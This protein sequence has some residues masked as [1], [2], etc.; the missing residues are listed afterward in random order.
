[1]SAPTGLWGRGPFRWV[2]SGETLSL[3]GD[4]SFQIVLAWLVLILSG[5]PA[6]LAGVLVA[7]AIPRGILLLVGGAV[8]DRWSPRTV[9]LVCH[10][11]RGAAMATL[12][13]SAATGRLQ[14]WQFLAVAV[15][16]GVADAFFWPASA[17]ILP[18][19]VSTAQLPRANAITAVGEQVGGLVGPVLGGLLLAVTTPTAALAFNTLTFAVAAATIARAPACPRAAHGGTRP[20]PVRAMVRDLRDGVG[21]AVADSRIRIVLLLVSAATLSYSGLFA[22]G[23]PALART[24]PNG[25]VVLGLLVS[26]WGLGQ[27]TGAL[28]ASITGLPRRWGLL[29][30]IMTFCEGAAFAVLGIAP[31]YLIAIPLLAVL[32]VGVA[33]TT[34]VAL[35]AFVQGQTPA[36]LLGR[37]NSVINLPRVALEPASIAGMGLLVQVDLRLTF[38]V[39]ALPMLLVGIALGLSPTARRLQTPHVERPREG[40][41]GGGRLPD[42]S[43]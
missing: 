5:S 40:R 1:M 6:T 28:L 8:T 13:A 25:S 7:A 14:T 42:A 17:S 18:S 2:V 37:V 30:I 16:L 26:A 27:L 22:V 21:Q 29:I 23:L 3:I 32:G 36:H 9:M 43:P 24:S 38:V 10:L 20:Q 4:S 31:T 39:A 11:A 12:T 19:L 35:P 15:G 41:A 34:D 33:Y